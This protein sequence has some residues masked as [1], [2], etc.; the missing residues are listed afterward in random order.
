VF[1][2]HDERMV[3]R[4]SRVIRLKDGFLDSDTPGAAARRKEESAMSKAA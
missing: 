1:V 3:E 2:T 4:C